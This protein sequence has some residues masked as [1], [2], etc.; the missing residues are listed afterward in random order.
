M[1]TELLQ[2][3]SLKSG[4]KA[5]NHA[6]NMLRITLLCQAQLVP[7]VQKKIAEMTRKRAP[8]DCT[9]ELSRDK[10]PHFPNGRPNAFQKMRSFVTVKNKMCVKRAWGAS[11]RRGEGK[12][13]PPSPH[14]EE[15][16]YTHPPLPFRNKW[17]YQSIPQS[18]GEREERARG[19]QRAKLRQPK[20]L[21][22]HKL[23]VRRTS[24]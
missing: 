11:G 6:Q 22:E 5:Y 4:T 14:R 18:H 3:T 13:P 10:N 23:I 16:S 17:S 2:S 19:L 21:Q 24:P 15:K 8:P 9:Q 12:K 7:F 1:V 20:T